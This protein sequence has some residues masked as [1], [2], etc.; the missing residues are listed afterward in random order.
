MFSQQ[1]KHQSRANGGPAG[2][3][4]ISHNFLARSAKLAERAICFA[5]VNLF[6][7]FKD[8]LK[9]KYLR[10]YWTVFI[11]DR[12]YQIIG[13]LSDDEDFRVLLVDGPKNVLHTY[14]KRAW[15]WLA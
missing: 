6:R 9:P 10:I 5:H 4:C 2:L 13:I 11:H 8:A 12:C 3:A 14:N 15:Q 1:L 7:S